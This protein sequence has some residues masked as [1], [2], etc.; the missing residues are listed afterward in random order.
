MLAVL[1]GGESFAAA[2]EASA[3]SVKHFECKGS[4]GCFSGYSPYGY[5]QVLYSQDIWLALQSPVLTEMEHDSGSSLSTVMI[6]VEF[7]P[8]T[9]K[10][11]AFCPI[12]SI[13]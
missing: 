3:A 10:R 11:L 1:P 4:E 6:L 5:Q 7:E 13:D 9:Q 8:A 12:L 2:D